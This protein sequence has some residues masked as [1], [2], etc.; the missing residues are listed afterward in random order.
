MQHNNDLIFSSNSIQFR[1]IVNLSP[2]S[3]IGLPFVSGTSVGTKNAPIAAVKAKI[4]NVKDVP[5]DLQ[6]GT[7]KMRLCGK[8]NY[9]CY[10][11]P[12]LNFWFRLGTVQ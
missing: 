9:N 8:S 3:P 5:I 10:L 7:G 1:F 12:F 4:K 11:F 2:R 6:M